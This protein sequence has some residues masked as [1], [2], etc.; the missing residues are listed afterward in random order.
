M[1][2]PPNLIQWRTKE[3]LTQDREKQAL[4]PDM[5]YIQMAESVL[6]LPKSYLAM[7]SRRFACLLWCAFLLAAAATAAAA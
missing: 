1:Q 4:D 3:E 2:L 5:E 6:V 7:V